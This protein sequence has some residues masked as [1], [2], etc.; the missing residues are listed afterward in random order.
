M[1]AL[2]AVKTRITFIALILLCINT[3]AQLTANFTGTPLSGCA[4]LVVNFTDQSAGA[5]NQWSWNLG[6]GTISIIQNPSSTYFTPGQYTIKLV[7]HNSAGNA[8]SITK[9]QYI[10][11]N[12]LPVVGFTG[13]P[14]TGCFPLPVHFTDQSNA[15][16]GVISQR[17]WDFG[18]G[19]T[20]TI[21]NPV[22]TYTA[23]GNYNVTLRVTNSNGCINSLT[24][25]GFVHLSQGVHANFTNSL[26]GNC[27][28]PATI[29][30][31]NLSSGTGSLNYQWNFGDGGTSVLI[32]PV[33]IYNATG[34]YTV[35][36]I[37]IN[38]GGC[39]DT[40]TKVNAIIIGSVQAN[41]TSAD[42]VCTGSQI[43]F[44]NNTSPASAIAA[45]DFGDGTTSSLINPVK[46]YLAPGP[47]L[48]RLI[49]RLGTCSD[50]TYKI[51]FV[52]NKPFTAF[53]A[54]PLSSCSKPLSVNFL[55]QSFNAIS[56]SW[57][58]G[59]GGTSTLTNPSHTYTAFGNYTVTLVTI[60]VL[61]CSD[62]LVKAAYIKMSPPQVT[63]NSLPLDGCSPIIHTFTTTI[64]SNDPVV[65][66]LWDFGDGTT[67]IAVNPTHTFGTGV[68]VIKL[69]I[70]TVS[71]CIDSVIYNP[72]V[73]ASIKPTANF[74]ASPRDVC[75][76]MPVM[77]TDLS[78]GIATNWLWSFG[79]G[80]TAN[81]QNP[82]HIYE[83]T[84]YFNVQLIVWNNGCSDTIRFANYIHIKPPIANFVVDFNCI[85]PLVKTFTDHSIGA[86][87]WNWDFGDGTTS[88]IQSPVHNYSTTGNY[89]VTLLVR[90]HTSGCE[91]SKTAI[92]QVVIEKAQFTV[93][94]SVICKNIQ[95]QF[96]ATGSNAANII[97]YDW[98]FGDGNNGT[99]PN[100]GH[101][102]TTAG[103]YTIRLIIT[104]IIGCRDTL[105]KPL[106]IEV[107]GPTSS[108]STSVPGVCVMSAL[109]LIDHSIGDGTHPITTW[110]WNYGDG[111]IDTLT[112]PPFQHA[113]AAPGVYSITLTVIDS[114]GCANSYYNV[115]AINI[116]KPTAL[117]SSADTVS[118]PGKLINFTDSSTGP[119]L[120][121]NWDFGDGTG[122]VTANPIHSFI[123]DGLYTIKL[124]ITDQYGCKDTMAK[125]NFIKIASPHASF[126]LSDSVGTCPPMFVNFTNSS[127]NYNAVNWDFGD[128]TSTQSD[129]PSHFYSLPGVYNAKLT[130]SSI[131]GCVDSIVKQIVLR[132]PQGSFT[133]GPLN[134]CMP[135]TINFTANTQDRLSF[136]WDFND[137]T[138]TTTNDSV[139][140][141]TYSSPGN[142]LPKMILVDP[143]GCLVPIL[144]I[145]TIKV[146]GVI[147][148]FTFVNSAICDSGSIAFTDSS[149]GNDI[150]MNY[151]WEFGDGA[152]SAIQNP[153]HFYNTPGTYFPRLIV[154]TL[155]GCTDTGRQA[156]PVKIVRSP[157]ADLN[158]SGNG[159]APLTVN[160]NGI[161]QLPDT[162]VINWIWDFGNGTSAVL[163]NPP[164]Q[165]YPNP[166]TFHIQLI[167]TNSTGCK[168]TVKKDLEVFH[169][170]NVN[171]GPDTLV[172]RGSGITLHA[173][174]AD[175]YNWSPPNGLSCTNCGNPVANPD[176]LTNYIVRGT[177]IQG[178]SNTDTVQVSIKQRFLMK[179]SIGDTLCK[180]GS[181]RL[182]ASGAFSYLWSPS[183]AL[184]STNTANPLASPSITTTYR[185]IGTD[186][187]ACFKDTGF[188][189]VKVYPIPTV[190]AGQDKT[191]NVGQSIE[192]TPRISSDV[193]SVLWFPTNSIIHS[194]FPSVTVKPN[195]TTNYTVEVRNPGGCISKSHLTVFLV[196]NGANVFIPNTF[197]P[198]GDGTNDIFYPRGIGLFRIKTMRVFNRWGEVIYERSSFM[199]NDASAG[200]NGT[201]KGL[202]LT[203]DVYV[204]TIEI[205]CD[206]SSTLT[207]KGNVTLLQ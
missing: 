190:E 27:N 194:N 151:H 59:D 78:T 139:I 86:D 32:N 197:S 132:G 165:F 26:P 112:A 17:Q 72:G 207:F 23:A 176:S 183:T 40:L 189:T 47:K 106:Y 129:N 203:P 4:P 22:H 107:D 75:A 155:N 79:D 91:Y 87:E 66:Y 97:S 61:G 50:T 158:S 105:I 46:I 37:V 42:S 100:P 136:I 173:I 166:G 200:W 62:T 24:R 144:G 67:S 65:N 28:A 69:F 99:G 115:S 123:N 185:V 20:G 15:G 134:G 57:D 82:T 188:V 117:F 7:V 114:K 110:I 119:G 33:H 74:S 135:L 162:S 122:A 88:S 44:T 204:Y 201:F 63:I 5:P 196:C 146:K 103:K 170:P 161:L 102:Y 81:T 38:S 13:T 143:G 140:S 8:D 18:D 6:N 191:I 64:T 111:I 168:D 118:C 3:K 193:T 21:Q 150:I 172:C 95:A 175:S 92:V 31:Q 206:N 55:N 80:G 128:G 36:L 104:D 153:T 157:R 169:I 53:N 84:G 35:R 10:T 159:C 89:P 19:S 187:K 11:V 164:P 76:H 182:F 9:I 73:T 2:F 147:A 98:S 70:T 202:K 54:S 184:S 133:Y 125:P 120:N 195:E 141:H 142:F 56:Y 109:S 68:Y 198:N 96:A 48:V 126:L 156:V 130:I 124:I 121:Y 131:G 138:I 12:A 199:P 16:S 113:Y 205:I 93:T 51:I 39:R 25:V 34:T 58:F 108:F 43:S 163:Q 154:T 167:A 30:F 77:F 127:Q 174:G 41:F 1:T 181:L 49:S 145:D 179:N 83:D 186:D 178:C 85:N 90:N 45:W 177:T 180:G 152:G 94:D 14:L 148:H 160:F 116:S 52:K 101:I 149:H 71:G 171:A 60:N 137:G 29:N 192:L